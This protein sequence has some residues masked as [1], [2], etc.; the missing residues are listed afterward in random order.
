MRDTITNVM[1][2]HHGAHKRKST[3][4]QHLAVSSP[5]IRQGFAPNPRSVPG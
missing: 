1:N 2:R 5:L 3:E 4:L